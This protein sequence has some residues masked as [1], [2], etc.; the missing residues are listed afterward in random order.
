MTELM[1]AGNTTRRSWQNSWKRGTQHGGHDRAHKSGEHKTEVMTE[2]MKAGNTTRRSWQ[3]SWKRETQHG[4]LERAHESG[5]QNT[6][7]MTKLMKVANTTW[8][9]WQ[10]LWK[11]RA[12]E[13]GKEM[14]AWSSCKNLNKLGTYCMLKEIKKWRFV[15]QWV[16]SKNLKKNHLA[17]DLAFTNQNGKIFSFRRRKT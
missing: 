4:G 8:R 12:S 7:V 3:S 10:S 15:L 5:Q 2:L 16:Q 13:K 14:D 6:E 1:K 17:H 9:P 11:Q